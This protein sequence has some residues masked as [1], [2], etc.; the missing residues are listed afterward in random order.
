[1]QEEYLYK[2]I[3]LMHTD[4]KEKFGVPRQGVRSKAVGKIVFTPKYRNPDALRDIEKFSH[5]WI[6]FDF[7]LSHR[8]DWSPTVRPPRLG[9]NTKTGVFASRSPNRPNP[10]GLTSVKLLKVEPSS[11]L[12]PILWVE[13]V[14]LVDGTPIL[15]VKPYVPYSDCHPEALGSF[16]EERK[17]YKLSLVFPEDLLSLIPEDKREVLKECLKDDPRPSY[18]QNDEKVYGMAYGDFNVKFKVKGDTL[19]VV[20]V[21]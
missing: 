19:T 10:I 14:D 15:D 5:L 6:I 20:E 12:G 9:G 7:S 16:A 8:E 2:V 21:S 17:D 1:M 18:I 11:P 3:A 13:G 4:F